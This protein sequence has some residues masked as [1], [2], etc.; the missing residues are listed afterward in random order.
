MLEDSIEALTYAGEMDYVCNW[1]GNNARDKKVEWAGKNAFNAANDNDYK[2][3]GTVVGRLRNA[4]G[5]YSMQAYDS[6]HL[7]PMDKAD[8]ALDML[9]K[10]IS[11]S[12]GGDSSEVV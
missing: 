2:L 3:D 4:K 9:I 10:F 11:G 5:F 12:V 7:V 8:V 1:C 6:G